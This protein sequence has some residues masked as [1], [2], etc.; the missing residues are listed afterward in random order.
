MDVNIA[1]ANGIWQYVPGITET[2][3]TTGSFWRT[4]SGT[5]SIASNKLRLTSAEAETMNSFLHSSVELLVNVPVAP[6]AGDVRAW[7]FKLDTDGNKGRAEFDITGA[8][9]SAKVY[10]ASGTII[11]TKVIPWN[12]AWSAAEARYRISTSERDIV[13]AIDD[14]IVARFEAGRNNDITEDKVMSKK[15][16]AVH[17]QNG[18]AD[19]MDVALVSVFGGEVSGGNV[20]LTVGDFEIGAVELKNG[21][22]DSRAV[23]NAANTA[24]AATDNVLLVQNIDAGGKVG[25]GSTGVSGGGYTTYTF[26]NTNSLGQGSV[27]Y[28]AATQLTVSDLSFT[29]A[30]QA[31][32]KIE[33]YTSVGVFVNSFSPQSYTIT[34][35]A[36]V[37]TV[38][39]ATFAPTDLFVIYQ[40]GPERTTN[41]ATNSQ[42]VVES[43]PLNY[44]VQEFTFWATA[45][46]AASQQYYPSALGGAMM[47]GKNLSVTGSYTN[48]HAGAMVLSVWGCNEPTAAAANWVQVF[49]YLSGYT[50]T[51]T[52]EM[53]AGTVVNAINNSVAQTI[54]FAWD[55]DNFNYRYYRLGYLPPDATNVPAFYGRISY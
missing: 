5:P 32:I 12:V 26:D 2:S 37:Y 47:G 42:G 33:Q 20:S 15:P 48:A 31:L 51:V 29:P 45:D 7:G 50:A 30:A 23:I 3:Y 38:T 6:T 28:T 1:R 21:T 14:T 44:Q 34:Y 9:F 16:I 19:N 17:L 8:V 43:N 22:D 53:T 36:G 46:V 10:D 13:F 52:S 35:A 41:L 18:N 40:Q 49:G 39:G 55:F 4:I 11:A 24:R 54:T 25:T 27:A